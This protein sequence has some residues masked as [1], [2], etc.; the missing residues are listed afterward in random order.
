MV[1]LVVGHEELAA[2]PRIVIAV[3]AT[4][5]ERQAAGFAVGALA[6]LEQVI[7]GAAAEPEHR[8]RDRK[9]FCLSIGHFAFRAADNL[10]VA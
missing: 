5:F 3:R 8:R 7:V 4:P 1:P 6:R 2:V 10:L 9:S